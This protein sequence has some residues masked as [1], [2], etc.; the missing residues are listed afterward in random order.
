MILSSGFTMFY[1]P[2]NVKIT[3]KTKV[4]SWDDSLHLDLAGFN[5]QEK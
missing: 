2:I 5:H 4:L 1:L 3:A